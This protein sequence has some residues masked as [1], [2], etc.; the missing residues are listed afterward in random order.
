LTDLGVAGF[1]PF[2]W[3]FIT[4]LH[5]LSKSIWRTNDMFLKAAA[6]GLM[7]GIVT[8]LGEYYVTFNFYRIHVWPIF[9]IAFAAIQLSL[10]PE[11]DVR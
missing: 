11:D 2:I 10:K 9:G 7:L 3:F 6:G 1:I 5:A 4:M 8:L